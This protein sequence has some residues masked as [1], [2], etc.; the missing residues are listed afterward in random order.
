[1]PING[2][3]LTPWCL[4]DVDGIIATLYAGL[5]GEGETSRPV[6]GASYLGSSVWGIYGHTRCGI[7][8]EMNATVTLDVEVRETWRRVGAK[9]LVCQKGI[10]CEL[11]CIM[12]QRVTGRPGCGTLYVIFLKVWTWKQFWKYE[13]RLMSY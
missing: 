7:G 10:W 5:A 4:I 3:F 12:L 9:A 11:V 6:T 8:R 2:D 1:M 13:K